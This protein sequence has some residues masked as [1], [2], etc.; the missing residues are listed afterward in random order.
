MIYYIKIMEEY[1]KKDF[2]KILKA[3]ALEARRW[4]NQS[5][6]DVARIYDRNIES[7]QLT[8]ELYGKYAKIV[9]Y[10]ENLSDENCEEAIDIVSRMVYVEREKI[11]FQDSKKRENKDQ[12]EKLDER[13]VVVSVKENVLSF[14]T[15]LTTHIDTGLFLD[16]VNT[17]LFVKENAFGL[18]VLN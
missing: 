18:S 8:V 4:M 15:D 13:S 6:S 1:V 2:A 14:I 12:H 7:L 3:N 10:D 9:N 16:H 11:I 17:R 5:D